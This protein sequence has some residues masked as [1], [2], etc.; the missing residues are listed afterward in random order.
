[1]F[2]GFWSRQVGSEG[3]LERIIATNISGIKW[4]SR[5]KVEKLKKHKLGQA[6]NS[7]SSSFVGYES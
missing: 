7:S 2:V 1:M 4:R 5:A 6:K 3:E